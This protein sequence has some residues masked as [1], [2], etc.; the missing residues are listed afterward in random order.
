MVDFFA[1]DFEAVVS[2]QSTGEKLVLKLV[3]V[4]KLKRWMKLV[5]PL[6]WVKLPRVQV[7][8][9]VWVEIQPRVNHL[10]KLLPPLPPAPRPRPLPP[11]PPPSQPPPPASLAPRPPGPPR[12]P[13]HHGCLVYI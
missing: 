12:P 4:L 7:W 11:P 13:S 6:V 9:G 5:M 3:L 8:M 10:I 2:T 1:K